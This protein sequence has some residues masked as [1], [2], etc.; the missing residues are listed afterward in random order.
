MQHFFFLFNVPF[1]EIVFGLFDNYIAI[2]IL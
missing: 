2:I 1:P